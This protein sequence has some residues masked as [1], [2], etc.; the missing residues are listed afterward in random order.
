M[1]FTKLMILKMTVL[2]DFSSFVSK[3]YE[4]LWK[5]VHANLCFTSVF[6]RL[7][8]IYRLEFANE[9]RYNDF[10]WRLIA[11]LLMSFTCN[12]TAGK[13]RMLGNNEICESLWVM[14]DGLGSEKEIKKKRLGK[15]TANHTKMTKEKKSANPTRFAKFFF[16][17]LSWHFDSFLRISSFMLLKTYK[18]LKRVVQTVV[19][20]FFSSANHQMLVV[21]PNT[22]SRD[23]FLCASFA[24]ERENKHT[25]SFCLINFVFL[26]ILLLFSTSK[27]E[28]EP[29]FVKLKCKK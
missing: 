26:F 14:E 23:L 9:R 16:V 24:N 4:L 20:F 19:N 21:K 8:F 25:K 29:H 11:C 18:L 5:R 12:F 17:C 1:K 6:M 13:N 15:E 3:S 28:P 22:K 10:L 7:F 2:K 27:Q